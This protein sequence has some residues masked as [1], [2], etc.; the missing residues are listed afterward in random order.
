MSDPLR[1]QWALEMISQFHSMDDPRSG[2]A[3]VLR[4]LMESCPGCVV[5]GGVGVAFYV[6]NPRATKDVDIVITDESPLSPGFFDRFEWT[7]DKPFTVRHKETGIEVDLLTVDNPVV[8]R[9]LLMKVPNRVNEF[10]RAGTSIRVAKPDFI[11]GLKLHRAIN[12]TPEGY[13]DRTDILTI[14]RDNPELQL[15]SILEHLTEEERDLLDDLLGFREQML[16][17]PSR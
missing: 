9:G 5:V 11:I 10:E 4:D 16:E 14:L 17:P 3:R 8:N 1:I 12:N 15:E 6:R 2:F 7:E 13:Q